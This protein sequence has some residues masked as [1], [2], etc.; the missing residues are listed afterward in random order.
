MKYLE[1]YQINLK[2][3]TENKDLRLEHSF[4]KVM[5]NEK[6][7]NSDIMHANTVCWS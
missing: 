5:M 4:Q 7:I 6:S 2:Q 3:K 1:I